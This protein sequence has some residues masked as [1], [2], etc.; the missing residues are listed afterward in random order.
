MVKFYQTANSNQ[1]KEME[2]AIKSEDWETFKTLI[3][4]V[5]GIMLK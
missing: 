2:K 1:I 3:R 4:K 5:V